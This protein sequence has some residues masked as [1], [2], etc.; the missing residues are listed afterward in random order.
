MAEGARIPEFGKPAKDTRNPR[1]SGMTSALVSSKILRVADEVR[2]L[3]ARGEKIC[4]LTVRDF[5][6]RHFPI[7]ETL[8]AAIHAALKT[9]TNYPPADGVL[10][11]RE[12]VRR[13]Y[14]R[15]LGLSYPTESVMIAGGSRPLIYA[16]FRTVCD[17]GDRVVYSVP[18]WNN[19]HYTHMVGATAVPVPCTAAQRFL[20][21]RESLRGLLSGARLLSLN[22]PLNPTGTAITADALAG[23]CDAVLEENRRREA[24]GER[25]LYLMYD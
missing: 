9:E 12:S 2:A 15:E 17:P 4:D 10:A 11:L 24:G 25:P 1:I 5:S 18:S 6:P 8:A 22:S 21:D 7:P 3:T 14:A 19:N 23:I 13:F 16:V 20:P